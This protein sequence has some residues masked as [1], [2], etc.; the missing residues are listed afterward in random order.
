MFFFC[1]QKTAYEMRISAWSSDVCSSDLHGHGFTRVEQAAAIDLVKLRFFRLDISP[2]LVCHA[3]NCERRFEAQFFGDLP[4][5]RHV[6]HGQSPHTQIPRLT[7]LSEQPDL[8]FSAFHLAPFRM[9]ACIPPPLLPMS[10]RQRGGQGKGVFGRVGPGGSR[11][12]KNKK[13][14]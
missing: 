6:G 12:A 9:S 14:K 11:H 5:Y 2:T 8:K 10:D 13:D 3:D 4:G 1:K 7:T